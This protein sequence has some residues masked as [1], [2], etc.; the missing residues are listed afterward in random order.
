MTLTVL[1]KRSLSQGHHNSFT[2]NRLRLPL[3]TEKRRTAEAYTEEEHFTEHAHASKAISNLLL[4][5]FWW[6]IRNSI[7]HLRNRN[8]SL[9]IVFTSRKASQGTLDMWNF[10][11]IDWLLESWLLGS[12]CVAA[13]SGLLCNHGK[14]SQ[15]SVKG[16]K[17]WQ[18]SR[19]VTRHRKKKSSPLQGS[20]NSRNQPQACTVCPA[21]ALLILPLETCCAPERS[22][23]S[24][25][26]TANNTLHF[27][28]F[29]EKKIKITN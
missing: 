16:K 26:N 24:G 1:A 14:R 22:R 20:F 12:S 7:S 15:C 11:V 18:N 28:Y 25:T 8:I 9:N 27:I 6:K 19:A 23:A 29:K 21:P 5:V 4:V 13:P 10:L 17:A 2:G 3:S